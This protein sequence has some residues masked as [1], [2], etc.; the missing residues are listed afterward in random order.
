MAVSQACDLSLSYSYFVVLLIGR[1]KESQDTHSRPH[2]PVPYIFFFHN[3]ILI[4]V[5]TKAMQGGGE[6]D[7][8]THQTL[9]VPRYFYFPSLS[10]TAP[11]VR[12]GSL[13]WASTYMYQT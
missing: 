10:L 5:V 6:P 2:L 1:E 4:Y 12:V 11:Y 9:A 8:L 13:R 3:Y 7:S